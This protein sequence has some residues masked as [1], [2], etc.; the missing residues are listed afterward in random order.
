MNICSIL[1][2]VSRG[3]AS[4]T[5]DKETRAR[6][7]MCRTKKAAQTERENEKVKGGE[8]LPQVFVWSLIISL[9]RACLLVTK[10]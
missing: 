4:R 10:V 8:T 5:S 7:T 1:R 6:V 9:S 2:E 3:C